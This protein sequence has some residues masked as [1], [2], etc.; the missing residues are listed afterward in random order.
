MECVNSA[1]TNH[2]TNSFCSCIEYCQFAFFLA[3]L[4]AKLK[5]N[6]IIHTQNKIIHHQKKRVQVCF[7]LKNTT[8]FFLVIIV[9]Q[10]IIYKFKN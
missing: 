5:L 4:L 1:H 9:N 8:S 6:E 3:L 10:E 2:S 7:A